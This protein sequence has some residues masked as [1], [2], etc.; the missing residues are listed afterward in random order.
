V[1]DLILICE[2]CGFP[3]AHGEGSIYATYQDLGAARPDGGLVHWHTRHDKCSEHLEES[4]YELGADQL[5]SQSDLARWT[6][7]LMAKRW[8]ALTDWDDLL[9]E[10]AGEIP[11]R[12]VLLVARG[13]AA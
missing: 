5:T 4:S 1:N 8:L 9:R 12:R 13:R 7:H 6:A 3:I 11:A 2:R 10:V